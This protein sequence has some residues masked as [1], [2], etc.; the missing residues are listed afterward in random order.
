VSG[1]KGFE[2]YRAEYAKEP[3]SIPLPDGT[4]VEVP[5]H[6]I[7][8][9]LAIRAAAAADPGNKF[10][11]L[12][13]PVGAENAAKIIEAWGKMPPAAWDALMADMRTAFGTKN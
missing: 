7:D 10:A 3:F 8:T 1:G 6:T 4:A 11:G 2:E 5:Q 13:I 9:V 12:E